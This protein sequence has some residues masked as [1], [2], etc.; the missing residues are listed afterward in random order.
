[1]LADDL[2]VGPW[3]GYQLDGSTHLALLGRA[4][5]LDA[6]AEQA[7]VTAK[8]DLDTFAEVLAHTKAGIGELVI[9]PSSNLLGKT[10]T[11][12]AMRKTYGLSV[13]AIHRGDETFREGLRDI[14][15]QAGDTLVCHC[16]WDALARLEKDRDFVVVTSEYPHEEL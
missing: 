14:P 11:D 16:S 8:A 10:V 5:Q 1:M 6:F 12:L 9:P 4:E 7:D 15:L 13:L 2:R 3:S